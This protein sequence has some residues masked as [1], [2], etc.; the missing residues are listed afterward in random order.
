MKQENRFS[1][2][3]LTFLLLLRFLVGWHLLYEGIA[4]VLNP[5][6]SSISFLQESRWILS[7]FARWIISNPTILNL[8]D[9][10]NTWGLIAIGLGLIMGLLF[11]TAAVAGSILLLLYYLNSPPLVGLESSLPAD[12][13][14]LIVNKT[15]IEAFALC[16]LALFSTS[17]ILGLDVLVYNY[18]N[19]TR[20][21]KVVR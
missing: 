6:W 10:L 12:G 2:L 5:Q 11:R 20:K 17:N 3:Q 14:N 13:S 21:D 15:L 1:K 9:F 4:K 19:H 16:V 8:V 18:K 7:G